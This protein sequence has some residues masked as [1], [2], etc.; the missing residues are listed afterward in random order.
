MG[1]LSYRNT[2]ISVT[3]MR[4]LDL[5]RARSREDSYFK[6]W[7]KQ[8][9]SKVSGRF[10]CVGSNTAVHPA[11]RRVMI[12]PANGQTSEAVRVSFAA[13]AL[14]IRRFVASPADSLLC[15]TRN[16]RSIDRVLSALGAVTPLERIEFCGI[17]TD[18]ICLDRDNARPE[19]AVVNE[20]WRRRHQA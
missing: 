6:T 4:W 11:W 18:I 16:D 12:D 7:P 15:L 1:V 8:A 10:V 17:E 2:C 5:S 19:G 3:G 14:T 20:L 13:I 9:V